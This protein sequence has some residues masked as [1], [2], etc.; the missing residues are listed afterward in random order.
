MSKH[1]NFSAYYLPKQ[2]SMHARRVPIRDAIIY[3]HITRAGEGRTF[4]T[5]EFGK[6]KG[7]KV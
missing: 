5:N 3:E 7:E 2:S 4:E 1:D 6:K